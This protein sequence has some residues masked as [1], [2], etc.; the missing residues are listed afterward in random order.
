MKVSNGGVTVL[1]TSC[2]PT[3][4]E[5]DSMSIG[6]S[7]SFESHMSSWSRTMA[8]RRVGAVV[9]D[10]AERD[11]L[12]FI[13]RA[14]DAGGDP[15]N[16]PTEL[17]E[18]DPTDLDE[19]STATTT[20][21]ATGLVKSGVSKKSRKRAT[22]AAGDSVRW[23]SPS[24]GS[25]EHHLGKC[26]PCAWFYKPVGCENGADCRHCHACPK[27]EIRRRKRER[28]VRGREELQQQQLLQQQEEEEKELE[29]EELEEKGERPPLLDDL[30]EQ[31]APAP[32][33]LFLPATVSST[34]C[35][36]DE[37]EEASTRVTSTAASSS[38]TQDE[39]LEARM[40]RQLNC[41]D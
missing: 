17:D 40:V 2:E 37:E 22:T 23:L 20:A 18:D 36:A 33:G 34:A 3:A 8:E 28:L 25:L 13:E 6:W 10:L 38:T 5:L 24:V 30:K 1:P 19:D 16:A 21:V 31:A 26:K 32:S 15:S 9:A 41:Q 39:S 35:A 11:I 27:G 12:A 29:L 7:S 4:E 14:A